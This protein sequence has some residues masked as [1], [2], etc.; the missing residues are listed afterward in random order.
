MWVKRFDKAVK[1][2]RLAADAKLVLGVKAAGVETEVVLTLRID[3]RTFQVKIAAGAGPLGLRSRRIE[4]RAL[5]LLWVVEQK[6]PA[7]KAANDEVEMFKLSFE[8]GET[9]LRLNDDPVTGA[10]MEVRFTDLSSDGRG[11]VLSVESFGISRAGLDLSAKASGEP[12]RLNGVDVPFRFTTGEF[13]VRGGRVSRAT[14]GG[15]GSLPRDLVGEVDCAILL[16]FKQDASSNDIVLQSGKVEFGK[17]GE[18]I[19]CHST[20]F[21]LTINDLDIAF[22][23]DGG[24]HFYFLVTGALAFTPRDG[25]FESGLLQFLKDVRIDLERAPLTSDPRVLMRH[26]SFQ[27]SLNPKKSFSL[28]NLFQFELRGFGFH[29]ASAKFGGSPAVNI[30]GQIKFAQIGDVMQPSID[31]HGLWIAPPKTG[32]LLPRVKADG[33]GIDIGLSGVAKLRGS[34]LAVDPETPS[35]EGLEFA[36]KGYDAYGFLG[37]GQLSIEGWGTMSASMGFMEVARK[38]T[39][40]D[41]KKSFFLYLEM[42]KLAV[43]IPVVVWSF[44][45]REVGFGFGYR[46]TLRGIKAA[47]EATSV[48]QLVKTLDEV[49]K[50][51][52]DLSRY[53]SWLPDPEGD[54]VTL[55]LRGAFQCFPAETTW[56]EEREAT[57][58]EPFFFDIVAA[59]R[60]DMTFLMA[61]RGWVATNYYDFLNDQTG[62]IRYHPGFRGYLFISAP[63]MELLARC[64][65]DSTG[66]VGDRLGDIDTLKKALKSVDW[67]MTLY[68]NPRLFHLELGW[69]NQL[70]ARLRE[71]Q[72]FRVIVRGGMIFRVA[73]DGILWGYNI[74][75]DA[76]IAFSGS[77]GGGSIGVAIEASLAVKFV[78][79]LIA[80]LSFRV[81]GTLIYGLIS[82]DVN[83]SFRVRAWLEIDLGIRSFTI[84][85]SFS[86]HVQFTAAVELAI[87]TEGVG[88]RVVAPIAIPAFGCMLWVTVRFTI[89]GSKLEEARAR[90]QRFMALGITNEVDP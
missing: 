37:E 76:F 67:S 49:S 72:N 19:V 23:R 44:Y 55:A 90:V 1:T 77:V 80:F 82:L 57:A 31:F 52:G 4:E 14:I 64:I 22:A 68:I 73:E 16:D 29:P 30:S 46:Y 20:R 42:N 71:D 41:R 74:E 56:S 39:P 35:L 10:R 17:K 63:R 84:R 27:K 8:N 32:E 75:A 25:E 28:F 58:E 50:R 26:V 6:D 36:P 81:A 45:L 62:A 3:L 15:R 18:P 79:R 47:E 86:F 53:T 24:Y 13:V 12:V 43:E 83:L 40:D 33:L 9:S 87:S 5:G 21:T 51:Q 48:A 60:S 34:V 7:K 70:V 69:P 89:G 11:V 78:A 88:A 54:N 65:G 38:E 61:A 2:A 85:I 59:L 66:Y